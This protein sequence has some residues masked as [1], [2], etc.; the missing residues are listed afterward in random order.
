LFEFNLKLLVDL[1]ET[2]VVIVKSVKFIYQFLV[3]LKSQ[4]LLHLLYTLNLILVGYQLLLH[5]FHDS[6]LTITLLL[7]LK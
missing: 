4:I 6:L 5:F 7:Q 3:V 2:L 1:L